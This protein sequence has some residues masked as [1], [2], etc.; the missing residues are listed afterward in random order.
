[1]DENPNGNKGDL[2]PEQA[3]EKVGC[4]G[5]CAIIITLVI[6]FGIIAGTCC[7]GGGYDDPWDRLERTID[8]DPTYHQW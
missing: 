3:A 6:C 5:G 4:I 2:T 7:N 1:M 8:S